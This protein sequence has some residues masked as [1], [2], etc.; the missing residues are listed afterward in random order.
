MSEHANRRIVET[1]WAAFDRFE[2]ETVAPMLHDDFVFEMP[3]SGERIRGRDNFIA[4]NRHYPGQWRI[5]IVKLVASEDEIV[6]EITASYDEQ[7]LPAISFF[8]LQDG[9]ILHIREFWPEPFVA[10]DWRAQWVEKM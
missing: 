4:M 7:N 9:K 10:Q 6:T 8:T 2:F 1:F 3:Q 5:T